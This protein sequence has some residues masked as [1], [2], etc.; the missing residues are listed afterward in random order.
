MSTRRKFIRNSITSLG[1]FGLLG[2]DAIAQVGNAI[3]SSVSQKNE[4]TF[5]EDEFTWSKIQQSFNIDRSIINLNNGGLSPS[6]SM[7]MESFKKDLDYSNELPALKMW[8]HLEPKIEDVREE[9]AAEFGC[10]SEEIAITRNASEALENIQFGLDLKA[11]DEIITTDNDYPRMLTTWDQISRRSGVIIHKIK[12]NLPVNDDELLNTIEK[13]ITPRTKVIHVSHVLF[14]TG[15][16]LPIGKIS[17]L[18]H[19]KGIEV[20]CDGAHSFSHFPFKHS[21]LGCDYFGTSLHKWTYAPVGTGFL[22]VRKDKIKKLWPL[23]AAPKKL[24]DNIRKFEEIGT[25]PAANHNAILDA[26]EFNRTLGIN[27]KAER[28]RYLNKLWI[29]RIKNYENVHFITDVINQGKSCG[30]ISFR[31]D[32]IDPGRLKKYLFDEHKIYFINVKIGNKQ[33]MRI[34]PNVYT[35]KEEIIKFADAIATYIKK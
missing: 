6:P 13:K 26:L 12:L 34:T 18:A 14:S 33:T 7:V 16:I 32:G 9:L 3:Q 17:K 19:N 24:D 2:P 31:I 8:K 10:D 22:Y 28:L 29:D 27:R 30:I 25:H 5:A 15:Q 23:M 1:V 11:A 35:T 4:V 20:I 21:D